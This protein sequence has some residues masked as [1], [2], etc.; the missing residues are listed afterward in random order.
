MEREFDL[1]KG[2]QQQRDMNTQAVQ[3]GALT[4]SPSS[5]LTFSGDVLPSSQN[6]SSKLSVAR[7]CEIIFRIIAIQQSII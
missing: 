1:S 3:V 2:S 7:K 4:L 6:L 5:L